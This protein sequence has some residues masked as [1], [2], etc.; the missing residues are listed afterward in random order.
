MIAARPRGTLS[1]APQAANSNTLLSCCQI[2]NLETRCF[3]RS[4][5]IVSLTSENAFF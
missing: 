3:M 4:Q 5:K 1:H 2:I